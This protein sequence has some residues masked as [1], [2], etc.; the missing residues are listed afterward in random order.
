MDSFGLITYNLTSHMCQSRLVCQVGGRKVPSS[1]G[2]GNFFQNRK[3]FWKTCLRT[4]KATSRLLNCGR[5]PPYTCEDQVNHPLCMGFGSHQWKNKNLDSWVYNHFEKFSP[6]MVFPKWRLAFLLIIYSDG[7]C[8]NCA[9]TKKYIF[10]SRK[11]IWY[12]YLY[13]IGCVIFWLY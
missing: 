13:S 1:G 3:I 7:D 12:G 4:Q 2:Q 5:A 10:T 8:N 6:L 11:I 9:I